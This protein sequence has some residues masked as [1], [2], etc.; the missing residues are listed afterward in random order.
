VFRRAGDFRCTTRTLLELAE[1]HRRGQP[2]GAARLLV[3]TLGAALLVGNS[4]CERVL[5]R[6]TTAAIEAGDLPLA[7]R[8]YGVLD[9]L[10]QPPDQAGLA[11]A[12]AALTADLVRTLENPACAAYV[13]EGRAGGMGLITTLYLNDRQVL[14][15]QLPEF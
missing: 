2:A 13:D 4:L 15:G 12:R 5:V 7:A 14:A 3:E 10:G 11:D 8:S 9:A 1:H 6:L